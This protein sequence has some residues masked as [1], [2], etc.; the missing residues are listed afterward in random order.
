MAGLILSHPT[1]SPTTTLEFRPSL[2]SLTNRQTTLVQHIHIAQGGNSFT[3]SPG[4]TP[5]VQN[6]ILPLDIRYLPEATGGGFAGYTAL[7]SF[8]LTTLEGAKNFCRL[9]DPDTDTF[10]LR[11]IRGLESMVEVQLERFSGQLLFRVEPS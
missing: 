2:V 8:I 10:V 6:T 5:V 4:G 1:T 11:Y 3:F 7:R 9:T